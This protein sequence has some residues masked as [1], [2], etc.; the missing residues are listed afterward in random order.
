MTIES[1]LMVAIRSG[2][3]LGRMVE[4]EVIAI[5]EHLEKLGWTPPAPAPVAPAPTPAPAP[6]PVAPPVATPPAPIAPPVIAAPP[7]PPVAK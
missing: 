7:A 6:V 2:C 4:S 5:I 1:A 3:A